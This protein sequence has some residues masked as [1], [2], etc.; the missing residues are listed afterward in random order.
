M[1]MSTYAVLATGP[2]MSQ[3]VVNSVRSLPTVAV[4]DAWTLAPH[5]V[6]LVSSDKAWW[7]VHPEAH[8]FEGRKFCASSVTVPGVESLPGTSGCNSGLLAVR[9][10]LH[11][12][13]ERVLLLGFDMHGDHFFGRHPEPLKN[14]EPRHFDR[15]RR[16]FDGW[17]VPNGREI[18]NCT[19]DSKLDT[20]PRKTL[21]EVLL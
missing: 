9:V 3:A 10:A 14:S 1:K 15:F 5:A 6:A 21:A 12:G 20:Y 16:Q 13:A 8:A 17:A 4:S 19:P 2:S 18:I 11:L 7:D